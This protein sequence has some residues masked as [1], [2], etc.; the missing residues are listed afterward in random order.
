MKNCAFM[1]FLLM[2]L[3]ATGCSGNKKLSGKV[4]F[5][6]GSPA[7]NG[8]VIFL[9]DSFTSKG[10]IQPDGS[11]KMSSEREN[12]G[13]PPGEYKVYVTGILE[14]PQVIPGAMPS[15]PASLC[16]PKYENPETSGLTCKIPAPGNRFDIKI[17]RKK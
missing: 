13:I 4:T 12:D 16:D 1:L 11:Y 10:E 8:T 15:M 7:P 3:I 17:E 14:P 2:C 9:K 5:E 6:D